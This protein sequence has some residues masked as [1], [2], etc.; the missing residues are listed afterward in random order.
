ML[1]EAVYDI[2]IVHYLSSRNRSDKY[3]GGNWLVNFVDH[4]AGEEA[5]AFGG[6]EPN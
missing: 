4:L 6:R 2:V 3:T 1:Q 5:K